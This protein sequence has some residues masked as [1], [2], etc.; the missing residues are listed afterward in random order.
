[1]SWDEGES[2]KVTRY[3]KYWQKDKSGTPLPYLNAIDFRPIPNSDQH[4]DAF[5]N[6][7][8]N[9]NTADADFGTEHT[10]TRRKT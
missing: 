4:F 1:V 7:S 9:T 2:L 3:D 8:G 10:N 6:A 5:G